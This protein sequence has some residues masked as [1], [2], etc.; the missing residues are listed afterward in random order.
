MKKSPIQRVREEHGSKEQLAGKL[1]SLLDRRDG[2]DDAAFE[3][4]IRTASNKQLLRLWAAEQRVKADFGGKDQLV[5]KIVDLKF[6]GKPNADYHARLMRYA[7][8]RLLDLHDS[9]AR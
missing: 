9:L 1:I 5:T 2:E 7:K 8:T 6:P 3:R 4:R